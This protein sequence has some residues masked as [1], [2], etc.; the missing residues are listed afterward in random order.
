MAADDNPDD[1]VAWCAGLDVTTAARTLGLES[2]P[3]T[4]LGYWIGAIRET[5]EEVGILLA[6]DAS[7]RWVRLDPGVTEEARRACEQDNRAFWDLLK[8]ERLIL[9]TDRLRY[10]AHWITPEEN[11]QRFDTRFFVTVA[12]PGQNAVADEHEIID[13]RWLEPPDALARFQ[14]G[15]ISLRRPT[16]ENIKLVSGLTDGAGEPPATAQA[17]IDALAG[18]DIPTIRPRVVTEQGKPRPIMPGEPG[19][20]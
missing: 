13:V 11:P 4:A 19:W 2:A 14:R 12:P 15:E 20:H 10:F 9:A 1:A 16:I 7:G 5:F 18:R 6:Y 8:G 3:R 17:A